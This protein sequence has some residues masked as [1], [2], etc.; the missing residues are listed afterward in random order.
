MGPISASAVIA[1]AAAYDANVAVKLLF[2]MEERKISMHKYAYHHVMTALASVGD[3]EQAVMIWNH[4]DVCPMSH[5][6]AILM[7]VTVFLRSLSHGQPCPL[8]GVYSAV[9]TL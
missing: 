5:H 9:V 3:V 1:C 8:L 7:L 2:R 6:V 4:M